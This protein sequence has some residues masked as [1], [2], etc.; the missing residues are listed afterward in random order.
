MVDKLVNKSMVKDDIN[1]VVSGKCITSRGAG[2]AMEFSLEL[3]KNLFNEH[4]VLDLAK[5][6]VFRK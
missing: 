4:K 3:V 5:R 1:V 2:T 6:L